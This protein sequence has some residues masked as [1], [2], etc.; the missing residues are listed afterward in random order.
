MNE[1]DAATEFSS[2]EYA[3][4][5]EAFVRL[6]TDEQRRL[7][8]YISTLLG[9]V[10]DAANVLQQTNMVLWR[11]ASEFIPESDFHAWAAKIAYYQTLAYMRDRKRDRHVFDEALVQ[12]LAARAT[13]SGGDELVVA[14]RHCLS[15]LPEDKLNLIRQRYWPGKSIGDIARELRRSESAVKMTLL[16]VRQT[17]AKCIERQIQHCHE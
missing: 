7:F 16:R 1:N 6:L 2:C 3:E 10:D 14:L 15:L 9:N 11:K 8:G 4:A 13:D 5:R 17:L 12:Q